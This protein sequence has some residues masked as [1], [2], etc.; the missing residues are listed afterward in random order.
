MSS[1]LYL[2][3]WL[4]APLQSWGFM[5]RF[6]RRTTGLFPTK[7]GVVGILAAALGI[8]SRYALENEADRSTEKN[9]LARLASLCMTAIAF[10][11]REGILRLEDYHTVMDT[12]AASGGIKKD[13]VLTRREYLLDARFGVIL[14]GAPEICQSA[15]DALH[16]PRWG[17]WLGRKSCI[18]ATPVL[19]AGSPFSSF[20]EAW[21]ALARCGGAEDS[22][23]AAYDRVEELSADA[24]DQGTDTLP[25]L[26]IAFGPTNRD[27]QFAPRRIKRHLKAQT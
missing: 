3:L 12:R 15:A 20:D 18:P 23:I 21:K 22:P 10:P 2:A 26:P 11:R 4:D 7:S 1:D 27:R 19:V 6:Q 9:E 14:S 17:L 24:W 8:N 25:D 13:A 16:N 5:S